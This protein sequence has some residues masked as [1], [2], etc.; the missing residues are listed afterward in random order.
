MNINE[1]S[2]DRLDCLYYP[3]SRLLDDATLKYL[4]LV[5]DSVTF[6][7]EVESSEWRRVLMQNMAKRDNPIFSSYDKLADDYQMLSEMSAVQVVNPQSLNATQSE[8]V[9]MSTIADLTNSEF[10]KIA[11]KPN[12]YGLPFRPFGRYFGEPADRPTWQSFVGKIATPLLEDDQFLNEEQWISHILVPEDKNH[13]WTFSYEA[14][15]AAVTNYY[16]E[17][18]NE[19]RLTP[20]TTSELHHQL[21]IH[22]LKRIFSDRDNTIEQ[23][24]DIERKRFRAISG[25]GELVRLLG[26]MFTPQK[27]EKI[28]FKNIMKFRLETEDVRR[29]FIKDINDVLRVIDSDPTK[30]GYDKEVIE[31]ITAVEKD[32]RKSEKEL[33]AVR[34]KLLPAMTE[35]LMFGIPGGG[36]LGAFV[37]FLGGF[38][39]SGIVA[40]SALTV[41]GTFFS[42]ALDIWN[43][44]R[45]I[46]RNQRSAVSYLAKI[47]KLVK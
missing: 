24:D 47:S 21:V 4:L 44:K 7:D 40:A 31:A 27:L 10:L 30:I 22:K 34:D 45:N 29:E 43:E 38:S 37:S 19:L 32:F 3:F 8:S 15:S 2:N 39:P 14:G 18:A 13:S 20:V 33:K 36:L 1:S 6:I 23:I 28:S 46:L 41:S 11:K 16:L 5:F 26:D 25:K 12:L 42:K 35:S 17:A 9:A